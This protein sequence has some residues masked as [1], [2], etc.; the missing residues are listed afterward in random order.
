MNKPALTRK[1]DRLFSEYW[2]KKIGKCEKCG[3]SNGVQLQLAHVVTRGI[4]KL[5]FDRDNCFVLC[6]GC[7]RNFHNRPLEFA[8]FVK[9]KKGEDVY[10]YLIKASQVLK[11]ITAEFYRQIIDKYK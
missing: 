7:H 9:K 6:A 11:P 10:K 3:R 2:R 4:R 1:A 8:D 5:R